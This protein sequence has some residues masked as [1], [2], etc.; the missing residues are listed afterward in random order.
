M[1]LKLQL[2]KQNKNK[3]NMFAD[4]KIDNFGVSIKSGRT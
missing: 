4:M 3:T 1:E 2:F